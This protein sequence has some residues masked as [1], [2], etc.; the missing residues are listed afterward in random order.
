MCTAAMAR[1]ARAK[2]PSQSA[3]KLPCRSTN[4]PVRPRMLIMTGSG[5]GLMARTSNTLPCQRRAETCPAPPGGHRRSLYDLQRHESLLGQLPGVEPAGWPLGRV[6]RGHGVAYNVVTELL[7]AGP[8]PSPGAEL[9]ARVP[10]RRG[11][12]QGAGRARAVTAP[13]TRRRRP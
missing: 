6:A 1:G 5:E 10:G 7:G 3:T 13:F 8:R 12:G 9:R 2:L 4:S 11:S